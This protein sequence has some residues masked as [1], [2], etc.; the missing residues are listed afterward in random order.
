MKNSQKEAE[1][2]CLVTRQA[3]EHILKE[4]D[5]TLTITSILEHIRAV[6]SLISAMGHSM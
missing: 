3:V 6:E 1:N 4:E 5:Q 2:Q